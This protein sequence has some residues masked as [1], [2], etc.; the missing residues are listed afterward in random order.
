[1]LD[2]TLWTRA[3][4]KL[5]PEILSDNGSEFSNPKEI[6]FRESYLH[7][8]TNVFCC[9]PSSPYQKGSCEVIHELIRRILPKWSSFDK[10]TQEY[11]SL[12]MNKSWTTVALTMRSA[13]ITEKICLRNLDAHRLL[14]KTSS[15][16][17]NFSR[18]N[19]KKCMSGQ[20]TPT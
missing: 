7:R 2:E 13:F 6:E 17:Q 3:F 8:R 4:N 16:S 1:M 19:R 9:D 10:L 11:I 18:S 20:I 5:F 12:M 14:P 15:W